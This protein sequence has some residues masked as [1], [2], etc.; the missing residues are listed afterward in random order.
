[1]RPLTHTGAKQLIPVANK[2]TIFYGIESL[3]AAGIKEIG[4]VVGDTENEVKACVGDGARWGISITYIFQEAPLGLAHAVKISKNF[5][6]ND[7]FVMYLGD[8]IL[9][10]GILEFVKSFKEKKPNAYIL[11][12]EVK[13]PEQFGV[14]N[15]DEGGRIIKLE[16][17]PKKP[18][19][20]LA[21]VGIYL[22]DDNIF[23]AVNSIKPSFRSELEITDAIKW[24]I[25]SGYRV[26]YHLVSG[27]WKDTGKPADLLE[28]NQLIL[29]GLETS[30]GG[31]LDKDSSVT[32][33]VVIGVGSKVINSNLRGPVI[34][35]QNVLIK[36]SYLGPFTAIS[37]G[38]IIENSEIEHSIV[39]EG[40]KIINV[41]G[42]IDQ[43]ILG[44]E[45]VVT[46]SLTKPSTHQF[47]LGDKSQV[48]I[49]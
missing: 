39:L 15:L 3:V 2:P 41:G 25:D 47:V 37:D 14:V 4:I 20:N 10:E 26:D 24:L 8:N 31:Q 48:T 7:S 29:E 13:N 22:F 28:A 11:L 5:L 30:I 21:L 32:G 6:E 23:K 46:S 27:W 44:K 16:E 1:M 19:S 43:S 36:N 40:S 42:R 9:K 35:G 18:K 17:K 33:R 38:V 12:T 49:A 34:I 45:V